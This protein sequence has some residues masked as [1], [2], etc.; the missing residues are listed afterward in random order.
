MNKK[1]I[2]RFRK[3]MLE[4]YGIQDA[5]A[6]EGTQT[7]EIAIKYAETKVKKLNKPVVS[8]SCFTV[9]K[10]GDFNAP[11]Y[12]RLAARIVVKHMVKDGVSSYEVCGY[13]NTHSLDK[14]MPDY[15]QAHSSN[16]YHWILR[17]CGYATTVDKVRR[18]YNCN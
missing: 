17:K 11:W 18:Y 9:A 3:W 7:E 12:V 14:P 16:I 13:K 4:N 1:E 6:Y 2:K 5:S 15:I 8:G 10:K